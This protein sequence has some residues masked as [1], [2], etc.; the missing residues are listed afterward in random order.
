[1]IY[2]NIELSFSI[3]FFIVLYLIYSFTI[4]TG[5]Y[6]KYAPGSLLSLVIF[7]IFII[8]FFLSSYFINIFLENMDE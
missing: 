1:M 6:E 2:N 8:L 5:N 4:F 3:F 7:I